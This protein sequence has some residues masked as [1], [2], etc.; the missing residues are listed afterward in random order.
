MT[1][2]VHSSKTSIAISQV[3]RCHNME[4]HSV[5]LHDC[6]NLRFHI[7]TKDA[8]L[9]LNKNALIVITSIAEES[10]QAQVIEL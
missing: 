5:N 1:V 9:L 8:F 2:V 7:L 4:G 3:A 10:H 6:K